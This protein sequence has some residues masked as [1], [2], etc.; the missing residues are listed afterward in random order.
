MEMKNKLINK[1]HS[2][3]SEITKLESELQSSKGDSKEQI[4]NVGS[5]V[6]QLQNLVF[7][8]MDDTELFLSEYSESD[9]QKEAINYYNTF[10]QLKDSNDPEVIEFKEKLKQS[11]NDI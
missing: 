1:I 3:Y 9:L 2:S 11:I 6:Y 4:I 7:K 10:K 8:F 5:K